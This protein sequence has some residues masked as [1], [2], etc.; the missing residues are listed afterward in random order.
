MESNHH[1]FVAARFG[2][3]LVPIERDFQGMRGLCFVV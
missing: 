1:V 3:A 2:D